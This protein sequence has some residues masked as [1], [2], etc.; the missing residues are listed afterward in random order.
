MKPK[1][2]VALLATTAADGKTY[3]VEYF[4]LEV[5]RSLGYRVRSHCR[6]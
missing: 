2:V 4:S 1:S 6:V 5:I 3:R